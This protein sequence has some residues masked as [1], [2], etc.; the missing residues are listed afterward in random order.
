MKSLLSFNAILYEESLII[1]NI[2]DY[3][4]IKIINIRIISLITFA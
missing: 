3:V 4:L 1:F 2:I